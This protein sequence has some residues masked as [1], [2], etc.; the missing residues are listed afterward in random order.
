M[1]LLHALLITLALCIALP[2]QALESREILHVYGPGGPA[3]AM[4]AA[5]EAFGKTHGVEVRVS[6]GPTEQ[7]AEQAS[8]DADLIYSGSEHMM[9]AFATRLP[10][11]FELADARPL[12]LRPSAILVRP[13]NPKRI[14]GLRDLLKPGMRIL[15]V[16]GAGQTGLWEDVSGRLGDID[17]VRAFRANIAFPEAGNS[18]QAKQ[19]WQDDT[20]LD[21]WLIWNIWQ[22]ANP[23]LADVVAIEPRYRI[24]RDCGIVVTRHGAGKPQA[25]AFA[26]FLESPE[27]RA[28]FAEHGWITR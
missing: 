19:R 13:G 26:E 22:H 4:K 28:I 17:T 24:H 11:L 1:R 16:S 5:A 15:V 2:T 9:G 21:A 8:A 27:A 14:R 7:W 20:S 6:A 10:G 12:Y 18:A 23:Q 3:P 25:R